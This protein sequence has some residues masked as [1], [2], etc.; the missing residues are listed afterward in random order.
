MVLKGDDG[1]NMRW[2]LLQPSV[3]DNL[4]AVDWLHQLMDRHCGHDLRPFQEAPDGDLD[5]AAV[6]LLPLHLN[7]KIAGGLLMHDRHSCGHC[8]CDVCLALGHV[9]TNAKVSCRSE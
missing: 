2:K 8:D 4:Y 9:E 5:N 1:H 7:G 3:L 6:M